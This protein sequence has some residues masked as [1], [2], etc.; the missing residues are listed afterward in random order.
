MRKYISFFLLIAFT[1]TASADPI[2]LA[3]A[4][5][6]ASTY[7][8]NKEPVLVSD[9][10]AIN[11]KRRKTPAWVDNPP[12]YIFSRGENKG[13][14]IVAGDDILPEIIGYTESGEFDTDNM[15]PAMKDYLYG[16]EMAL[17]KYSAYVEENGQESARNLVK[18]RRAMRISKAPSKDIPPLMTSAWG[19]GWPYYDLC[20]W[21]E[22]G[23]GRSATGCVATSTS[24]VIHYWR[25]DCPRYTINSTSDYT[26]WTKQIS[27]KGYP[28]G[29]PMR[30]EL[31]KDS[32]DGTNYGNGSDYYTSASELVAIVGT[33]VQMDYEF[34]SSGAQT[35]MQPNALNVFNLNGEE[36]WYNQVGNMSS[37]EQLVTENLEN[38]RPILYSGY[39][40]NWEGHAFVLDGYRKSDGLYF[41]DWGWNGG[42]NGYFALSDANGFNTEQS[43][44]HRIYPKCPNLSAKISAPQFQANTNNAVTVTVQNNGSLD[45]SAAVNIFC[46]TSPVQPTAWENYQADWTTIPASGADVPLTF[47]VNP[48]AGNVWYLTVVDNT[49]RILDRIKVPGD[50]EEVTSKIANPSFELYDGNSKPKG[51]TLGG[52]GLYSRDAESDIWRAVGHDGALVLDSWVAGDT[53][54]GISQN[55]S[56]LTAGTYRL[57][58]KVATDKGNTV[59]VFAGEKTATS[60]AHECGKYYLQ[61]VCIDGISVGNDGILSIG[62]KPGSWYKADDFRLYRYMSEPQRV[63]ISVKNAAEGQFYTD[64]T[65]EVSGWLSTE[66]FDR[67]INSGFGNA[68]FGNYVNA[69]D[70]A[71]ISY[72]FFEVWTPSNNMLNNYSIQQTITGLDNGDYYIGG[73]FISTSQGFDGPHVKGVTFWAQ[74]DQAVQLGTLNGTPEI[75]SLRVTVTDGTLTFGVRTDCCTANWVALD[76]LFLYRIETSE[77]A[78]AKALQNCLQAKSTYEQRASGAATAALEQYEWDNATLATKSNEEILT[79]IK[80]LKNGT[81]IAKAGQDATSFVL[82]ADLSNSALNNFAPY[83]WNMGIKSVEGGGDVWIREQDGSNVYNIWYPTLND[84]EINQNITGLPNGT[85]RFTIDLGTEFTGDAADMVAFIIG[86]RV[87]ASNQVSTYNSG[88]ARAFGTYSCAATTNT[89]SVFFGIRALKHYIQ[90]KNVRL[91]FISG[92]VAEQETD[93]SYLRQDYFWGLRNADFVDY[94]TADAVSLYGNAIDVITYPSFANQIIYAATE[95][96]FKSSQQNVVAEGTCEKL[97]IT[98]QI[99]LNI[100]TAFDATQATYTREMPSYEDNGTHYREWG[101]LLLPYPIQSDDNIQYYVLEEISSGES[102]WMNFK[103]IDSELPANTPVV[104]TRKGENDITVNGNGFVSPTSSAQDGSGV[105]VQGWKLQ[106][107]YS[108]SNLSNNSNGI[109][110]YIAQDKFWRNSSNLSVSPFRAYFIAPKSTSVKQY[111]LRVVDDSSTYILDT[112]DCKLLSGDIYSLSGMYFGNS[113]GSLEG[114]S[115]GIYIVGGRK[116]IIK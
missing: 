64:V 74:Q 6:L 14:V 49:M 72:P 2:D 89:N 41:F 4:K 114:L 44:T 3:K 68:P 26:T 104:F 23:G 50:F 61:D 71:E 58:A 56:G 25:R 70:G 79:A 65:N 96:Q 38:G 57:T 1:I 22:V 83:G 48:G 69:S 73:S 106:G 95:G 98:D 103:K 67:Y 110:Y 52:D 55:V 12:Y 42:W 81:K 15:P 17:E 19:Q 105:N 34:G 39:T 86:E 108:D 59:T 82:N 5:E 92:K 35:Y 53:G 100:P 60:G 77:D 97:V 31:M 66:S 47:T 51:W 75:Y 10:L 102:S 37:W 45:Y 78:Y 111:N 107:V 43:M 63:L 13:F 24:S 88:A 109:I 29:F 76:N 11:A 32:Y 93:A 85:Y 7:V 87:G 20:P 116:V 91:E 28:A 99:H 21:D 94:T 9:G 46:T 80:I 112:E 101:T 62:V 36:I 40:S 16:Y 113:S 84:L 18:Q 54:Y 27:V 115:P 30:W 33:A 90:M 8:D